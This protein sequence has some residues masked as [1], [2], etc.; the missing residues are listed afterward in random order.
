M[1]LNVHFFY[2]KLSYW[3]SYRLTLDV[4]EDSYNILSLRVK[5]LKFYE[6]I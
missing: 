1:K 2:K 3:V 6:E 5:L 4:L